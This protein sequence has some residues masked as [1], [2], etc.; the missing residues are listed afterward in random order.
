VLA[1]SLTTIQATDPWIVT[2]SGNAVALSAYP[3]ASSFSFTGYPSLSFRR[4]S[5]P[6]TF[7]APDDNISFA[8]YD[9]GVVKAGPSAKFVGSRRA[10]DH[11]E[12]TGLRDVDWTIESG[13]FV[14]LWPMQKLRTRVDLRY[15][16]HGHGGIVADLG[17]DYVESFRNWILSAGPRASLGNG[18]FARTYFSVSPS[19]AIANGR[20]TP[21]TASGGLTSLGATAALSYIFS[22]EWRATGYMRYDHLTG[23]PA[24]SPIIRVLGTSEQFTY[25]LKLSYS[26]ST[27]GF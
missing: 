2:V 7:S 17:A 27:K 10:T 6:P 23:G 20:I 13:A 18:S 16:L 15:G 5:T 4:A 8:I 11:R 24:K 14:E 12:L 25:G 9:N 19:E 21:Y 1:Q 26:F 22:P 3:G